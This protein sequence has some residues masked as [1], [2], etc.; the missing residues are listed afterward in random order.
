MIEGY[1]SI[2]FVKVRISPSKKVAFIC[3]NE[4][5]LKMV[6][7]SFDII[8]KV[9]FSFLRYLNICLD[10]FD[11]VGKRPDKKAKV[12]FKIYD[13]RNWETNHYN[14]HVAQYFDR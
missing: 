14:T 7:N 4:S 13:V 5:S 11:H 6:K 1:G 3:F 10:F 12:N 9:F 2:V 8:S